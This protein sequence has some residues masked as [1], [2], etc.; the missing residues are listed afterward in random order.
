MGKNRVF[1]GSEAGGRGCA[2]NATYW[3]ER[4]HFREAMSRPPDFQSLKGG[5]SEPESVTFK[6]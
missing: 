6:A 3:T 5:L 4:A 1:L 2:N